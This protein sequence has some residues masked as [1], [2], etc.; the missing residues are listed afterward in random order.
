MATLEEE[1]ISAQHELEVEYPDDGFEMN[2]CCAKHLDEYRRFRALENRFRS[3]ILNGMHREHS[4]L[5]A[6][7]GLYQGWLQTKADPFLKKAKT[8]AS[9]MLGIELLAT[10]IEDARQRLSEF[11]LTQASQQ[12]FSQWAKS[13]D[14]Y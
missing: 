10:Y 8:S 11:S 14:E 2:D 9:P 1:L 4:Q 3:D 6:I 5:V 13:E 12:A 7:Y